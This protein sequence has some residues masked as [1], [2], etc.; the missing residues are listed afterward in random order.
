MLGLFRTVLLLVM[1]LLLARAILRFVGGVVSGA[2]GQGGRP[3]HK[4]AA[5]PAMRM[6]RDPICGTYVVPGKALE[7]ARGRDTLY[8]C[9]E[10]CRDQW[11]AAR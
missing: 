2:T 8:F 3:G 6:V 1:L 5:P 11:A 9:S 10:K 4:P 7:L